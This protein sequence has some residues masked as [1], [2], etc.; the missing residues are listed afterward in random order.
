MYD[1]WCRMYDVGCMYDVRCWFYD[2]S[3]LWFHLPVQI[4]AGAIIDTACRYWQKS[5]CGEKGSCLLYNAEDFR[6]KLHVTVACFKVIT[7]VMD[8]VVS[9]I[10]S[11]FNHSIGEEDV[12][13]V[14]EIS[15]GRVDE[16]GQGAVAPGLLEIWKENREGG[17]TWAWLKDRGTERL[18]PWLLPIFTRPWNQPS[19]C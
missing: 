2:K 13:K 17:G 3:F 6:W 9:C 10:Q 12:S 5:P 11:S 19:L 1:V 4:I 16:W 7:C 15:Q 18:G 14:N 8:L